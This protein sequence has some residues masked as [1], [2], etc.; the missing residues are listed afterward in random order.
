[1]L[2]DLRVKIVI[3]AGGMGTRISEETELR[4]KPMIEIGGRPILWHIM[5]YYSSFGFHEFIICLGYKGEVIKKYFANYHLH[6]SDLTIDIREN[7]IVRHNNSAE[8]WKVTLVDTGQGTMTGGRLKRIRPYLKEDDVAMVTYGDGLADVALDEL[9]AFHRAHGKLATLTAVQPVERFGVLDLDASDGVLGF[10]EKPRESGTF[11]N[12][13]FFV[14]HPK[15]LDSIEGDDTPWERQ[16]LE[17]L[18]A[19]G[20]LKA[21]RH[22]GFWQC[23]DTLRDKLLLEEIWRKGGAPWK[24]WE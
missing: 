18:A 22:S 21:F 3:L 20:N 24:R 16:P 15:T 9:L 6:S 19:E 5:K 12:G 4:P 1:L 13:G 14:I 17:R 8:P 2:R 7:R 23:M 10:R 11:V